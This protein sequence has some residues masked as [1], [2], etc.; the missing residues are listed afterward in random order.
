MK[1]YINH[2][3]ETI[4]NGIFEDNDRELE[5]ALFHLFHCSNF[6]F[7]YERLIQN[8]EKNIPIA[9]QLGYTI[10]KGIK[11]YL[12]NKVLTPGPETI[13]LLEKVILFLKKHPKNYSVLDLCA[14]SGIFSVIVAKL[15][16]NCQVVASDIDSQAIAIL[17]KNKGHDLKNLKVV[18][19]NMFDGLNQQVFD[20]IISNPPYVKTGDI[21]FLPTFVRDYAPKIAINGQGDGLF[22]HRKILNE[23]HNFLSPNGRLFLECESGQSNAII[24]LAKQ[25]FWEIITIYKN[26]IGDIRS[27]LLKSNKLK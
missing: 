17:K 16:K 7:E 20:L 24:Q 23:G 11:I 3:V 9:N 5:L 12:E 22:F 13:Y 2:L 1:S 19:G 25:Y 15:F 8:F 21:Q 6:D 14:G 26:K 4:N 18:Q 27:F 10:F